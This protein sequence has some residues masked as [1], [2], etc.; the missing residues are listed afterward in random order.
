MSTAHISSTELVSTTPEGFASPLPEGDYL[1]AGLDYYKPTMSQ[2]AY[3]QEPDAEV[4]F[5]FRNRGSQRLL[6]YVDP[7]M[8]HQRFEDIRRR[9]WSERELDYLGDLRSNDGKPVFE[10]D[11]LRFLADKSLPPV[12]IGHDETV[13]DLTIETTG[14]CA[15]STFWET[16][17]MSEVNEAYFEGYLEA[18]G[19]DPMAVYDEGDRRLD[20]KIAILRANPDIQ[21]ADFGTRRHFSLRWQ[22]HVLGRLFEECPDNLVGTSNVALA[23]KYD[24]PPIGT[25]AH[26]MP[27]IYAGLADA[28]GMDI[29]DSHQQFLHDWYECYGHDLSVALTDTFTT[30][31]FFN[32]FTQQQAESWRGVRHDSGDPYG[33]GERLIEFYESQGVDPQAKTVVFSDGLDIG[34]IVGLQ[35]HFEG[36]IRIL[37]GWGTTLTNDL[38]IRP[39]NVVMKAT[40]VRLPDTGQEADTVKLSDNPGKHTGPHA[41]VERYQE[42]FTR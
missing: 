29:R 5:T 18:H 6:D 19:L 34:Q 1:S 22:T 28:R 16:I 4:T 35:E 38:G 20:E 2:L 33:F 10:T 30:D 37:F 24:L 7:A 8:L 13:D 11:Y 40:H 25:F 39:L 12:V 32:D 14:P 36:R 31:F 15:L 26:E 17:V 9:G 3:E 27:M 21:F 42:I 41:Q 23:Q